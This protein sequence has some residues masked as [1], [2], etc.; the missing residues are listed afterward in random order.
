MLSKNA[1]LH[2]DNI[3]KTLFSN[4]SDILH[5]SVLETGYSFM[6]SWHV[7]LFT[8]TSFCQILV[9]HGSGYKA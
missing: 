6:L 1:Q 3:L 8:Y 2:D 7:A 5:T 9:S 4:I